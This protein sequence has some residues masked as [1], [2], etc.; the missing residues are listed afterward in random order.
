MQRLSFWKIGLVV[1]VLLYALWLLVPSVNFYSIPTEYRNNNTTP[2]IEELRSQIAE[3]PDRATELQENILK[4][5]EEFRALKEESLRL[6]LDLQGGVHMVLDVDLES[7]EE[8]VRGRTADEDEIQYM[9]DTVL[10]S[11]AAIVENRVD[12]YGVAE[13]AVIQ[14]EPRRIVLEMPGFSD[15]DEIANLVQLE[16]VLTFHLVAPQ[17]ELYRVMSDID[18]YVEEDVMSLLDDRMPS[19]RLAAV[20]VE[21]PGP[22]ELLNE[23]ITREDVSTLTGGEYELV[24]GGEEA[25][26][27]GV[28]D[29]PHRYLYL[30]ESRSSLQG[31]SI[32]NA[33]SQMN[34]QTGQPEV[35]ITL[36]GTGAR[37]FYQVT[38]NNVNRNLAIV[39]D[40]RVYS[41]PNIN[42][43]ISGGQAQITGIN[44]LDEARQLSVV[45]QAGSL[46]A[47]MT[48]EN[49]RVVGPSLGADS[50]RAGLW[51]GVLGTAIVLVFMIG[52]YMTCGVVAS[53]TVVLN[54]ILLMA[55]MAFFKATL[56][57]PGIAGIVLIIGMAVDA[58]VLIYE[59]MREE[60][61]GKRAR[62]LALVL[63]KAF[64]RA[65]M[66]IFDANLTSL[67]TALVL[68]QFG[69]GPIKGFAVTLSLGI[70]ISLFTAV[71]VN[72]VIM[73]SMANLG[74][75]EISPGKFCFF[76]QPSFDFFKNPGRYM[77]V[78]TAFAVVGLLF[79]IVFWEARK[80]IDF[81]G[82][83]EIIAEF[84]EPVPVADV[85]SSLEAIGFQDSVVQE[86]Y[87]GENQVLIRVSEGVVESPEALGESLE[88][89]IPN[90]PFNVIA[91]EA[92]GAKVGGELLWKGLMCLIFASIG[93]LLYITFRF[94]F[95]FALA[96]VIALFHDLAFTLGV[97]AFTQTEFNLPIIAALLTVLGYSLNDTIVVF[98][99]IRENY[100]SAMYNFKDVVNQSINQ[101]LTRTVNT[102]VTT[103]FVILTLYVVGGAVIHDFAF[104]LMIGVI[105]GT[106]SSIFVA[107]PVLILLG[108]KGPVKEKKKSAAEAKAEPIS[109]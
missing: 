73:D 2:A 1:F 95:R 14:Q 94:E 81:A 72:R 109:I 67:I 39:M 56:T 99:R 44:D 42:Q 37:Q 9:M 77:G 17:E 84:S 108:N 25:P 93:I 7:Y 71:F 22:Y 91:S 40:N 24:W 16:A 98:D 59:R 29:F 79:L 89:A 87:Q 3:D 88:Q 49:S 96:A 58:N 20:V 13:A 5:E 50:V 66:T 8:D 30:I 11:A 27:P 61:S 38:R 80:G 48:I 105:V 104:T 19:P 106:Y 33:F 57:L 32:T 74:V 34:R 86:V 45:L 65:F 78:S 52:Y 75:K 12:S 4:Q 90:V 54:L 18:A 69:T 23:I 47:P 62:S 21:S 101:T 68:F 43:E 46:P 41:A 100:A 83:T 70:L 31:D 102:S 85:R 76:K 51:A 55:G 103:L 36:D 6:G 53:F 28:Y 107:S 60:M 82:G 15:P 92:V 26:I 97:L 64:G 35:W 10:P 63:D